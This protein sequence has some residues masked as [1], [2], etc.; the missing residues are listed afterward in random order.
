M[1]SIPGFFFFSQV[2]YGGGCKGDLKKTLIS[3]QTIISEVEGSH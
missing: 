3:D 1:T 2:S